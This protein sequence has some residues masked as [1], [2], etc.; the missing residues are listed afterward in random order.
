[1][2]RHVSASRQVYRRPVSVIAPGRGGAGENGGDALIYP[3]SATTVISMERPIPHLRQHLSDLQ[4]CGRV[5][6][7]REEID[8]LAYALD[9]VP[10]ASVA[11]FGSRTQAGRRGGDI[12]LLVLTEAPAFETS[13]RVAM[14]FFERCEEKIDVVV[15]PPDGGVPEQRAFLASI[16]R[17]DL[18]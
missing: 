15:L 13:R 3:M 6:L 7:D 2:G 1:M 16:N 8:A 10:A 5:R 17:V 9:G 11:L 4:R 14:R 18:A 12:D